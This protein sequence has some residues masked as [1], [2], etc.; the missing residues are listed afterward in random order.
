MIRFML[1]VGTVVAIIVVIALLAALCE[2]M[3]YIAERPRKPSRREREQA[4]EHADYKRRLGEHQQRLA[5][6]HAQI[7][8]WKRTQTHGITEGERAVAEQ[9]VAFLEDNP[10]QF[11]RNQ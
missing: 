2:F 1:I 6:H 11:Q 10:P 9:M 8:T 5:E 4:A 7:N 3:L